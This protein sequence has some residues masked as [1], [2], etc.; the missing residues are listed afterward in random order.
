MLKKMSSIVSVAA[1][2][3]VAVSA[4]QSMAKPFK[5]P[6]LGGATGLMSMPT[7][8]VGWAG[9]SNIGL[10]I[11]WHYVDGEHG[12]SDDGTHIPKV[13]VT[14]MGKVELGVAYDTQTE[15]N[16]DILFHGKFQFYGE[17]QSALAVGGNYQNIQWAGTRHDYYQLYLAATYTGNFISMPAETSLVIGKTFGDEPYANDDN[18]DFAMGF[19]LDLAPGIFKHYI[20]WINDFSN[21]SYSV[22]PYGAGV[23]RG[24]F[25]TGIR[26]AALRDGSLKLNFDVMLL[27]ALDD[28]RDWA[29]GV[30]FGLTF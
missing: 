17:G 23:H 4:Q 16:E 15:D 13:N 11:G 27:D 14:I 29:A 10:D 7:A 18:I 28:N 3:I 5:S 22:N 8:H 2:L 12:G 30:C 26:I 24:I 25:N 6:S 20:H 21:F 1:F 9:S 19:D